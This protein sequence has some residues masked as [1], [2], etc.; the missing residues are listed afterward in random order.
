MPEAREQAALALYNKGHA[1]RELNRL[2]EAV[3][4]WLEP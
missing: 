3:G 2:E 4:V 1:L